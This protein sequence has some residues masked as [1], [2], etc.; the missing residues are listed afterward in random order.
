MECWCSIQWRQ[1]FML[2][3]V[4]MLWFSSG[5]CQV[6]N[7]INCDFESGTCNWIQDTSDNFDW[8]RNK[9]DTPTMISGPP[10]D[11]TK[12]TKYGHYMYIDNRDGSY[13]QDV[14][15]LLSQP[16]TV[17]GNKTFS[18]WIHKNGKGNVTLYIQYLNDTRRALWHYTNNTGESWIQMKQGLPEGSY[19]LSIEGNTLNGLRE[20]DTAIDDTALLDE[21]VSETTPRTTPSTSAPLPATAD[22]HFDQNYCNYNLYISDHGHTWVRKK[23]STDTWWTGPRGDHTT[24]SGYFMYLES[25]KMPVGEKIYMSTPYLA[26]TSGTCLSVWYHMRGRHIGALNVYI[27][28]GG[29]PGAPVFSRQGDQGANWYQAKVNIES[30]NPYQIVFEAERGS[31]GDQG[32]IALDDVVFSPVKCPDPTKPTSP[33]LLTLNCTFDSDMCGFTSLN[34]PSL[35]IHWSRTESHALGGEGAI[36]DHTSGKGFFLIADAGKVTMPGEGAVVSPVLKANHVCLQFYY[37]I[38][39][40]SAQSLVVLQNGPDGEGDKRWEHDSN[41][42][43]TGAWRLQYVQMKSRTDFQFTFETLRGPLGEG[44]IAIDDVLTTEGNCPALTTP[45]QASTPTPSPMYPVFSCDFTKDM[46]G[47]TEDPSVKESSLYWRRGSGLSVQYFTPGSSSPKQEVLRGNFIYFNESTGK[48]VA[49]IGSPSFKAG[50]TFELEFSYRI[51]QQEANI[52]TEFSVLVKEGLGVAHAKWKIHYASDTLRK[53]AVKFTPNEDFIIIFEVSHNDPKGFVLLANIK[54]IGSVQSPTAIVPLHPS[55]LS[56]TFDKGVCGFTQDPSTKTP[57]LFWKRAGN[58]TLVY[59]P[60]PLQDHTSGNGDFMY[61]GE[62]ITKEQARLL[63]PTMKTVGTVHLEFYYR[64]IQNKQSAEFSVLVKEGVSD[65]HS[66]WKAKNVDEQWQK[67]VVDYSPT[68]ND[69]YTI[70]FQVTENPYQG[71]VILDDVTLTASNGTTSPTPGIPQVNFVCDFDTD[72]CG[73]QQDS[74]ESSS[75]VWQRGRVSPTGDHTTG[76]G[77]SVYFDPSKAKEKTKYSLVTPMIQVTGT[78]MCLDIFLQGEL[79][80]LNLIVKE[81]EK[82]ELLSPLQA[83]GGDW[84]RFS[85]SFKPKSSV[86]QFI[87]ETFVPE[88]SQPGILAMDD[89]SISQGECAPSTLSPTTPKPLQLNCTFDSGLCQYT[90]GINGQDDD[91]DWEIVSEAVSQGVTVKDHTSGSGNFVFLNNSWAEHDLR[92]AFLLSPLILNVPQQAYCFSFWYFLTPNTN[93]LI[94]FVTA[95]DEVRLTNRVWMSSFLDDKP[96]W[97]KQEI[98]VVNRN[99]FQVA[100]MEEVTANIDNGAVIMALDDF[101]IQPGNCSVPRYCDSQPCQNGGTC[102]ESV[103]KALCEC[104]VY[105]TGINCGDCLVPGKCPTWPPSTTVSSTVHT[106]GEF[107]CTFTHNFLCGYTQS[108]DDEFDWSFYSSVNKSAGQDS[109]HG[110]SALA[111]KNNA[112]ICLLYEWMENLD[113]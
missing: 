17:T 111:N 74:G 39:G 18:V 70:I 51:L 105:Y 47:L 48:E 98:H 4:F 104:T 36:V 110:N 30:S 58:L 35:S 56:C 20:G 77:Q 45:S 97:Q 11:H 87:F 78:S 23:G 64:L 27:Q 8:S 68:E 31:G 107:S 83:R 10:T 92:G 72:W 81:N 96:Q 32:D 91:L 89:I 82:E 52:S 112:T 106:P 44:F 42:E 100:F 93:P 95:A 59:L 43:K 80:V 1:S 26:P 103:G 75:D 33:A 7:P 22:C 67:G 99:G 63:S 49:R 9:V 69:V 50:G 57:R 24:G 13:P 40:T 113:G 102:I 108:Q 28:K 55:T 85:V 53:G 46:C 5:A 94:V 16:I 61:F 90:Q 14:A 76:E 21:F 62:A 15:R 12:K 41:M 19:R 34:R 101:S 109:A 84:Q 38:Y 37:S 6:Q 29:D 88:N 54:L 2:L 86:F 65:E 3:A 60:Q 73:L 71:L 25:S 66:V 79:A